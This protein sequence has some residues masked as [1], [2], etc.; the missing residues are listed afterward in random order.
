MP[1]TIKIFLPIINLYKVA[2]EIKKN[3]FNVKCCVFIC[4]EAIK[5]KDIQRFSAFFMF[6]STVKI[7][8]IRKW[9]K[10]GEYKIIRL[11]NI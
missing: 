7:T 9:Y 1:R 10:I 6:K 3:I 11:K 2:S 4:N 5:S 8:F